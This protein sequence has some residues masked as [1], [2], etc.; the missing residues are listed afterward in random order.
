M[1]PWAKKCAMR[2]KKGWTEGYVVGMIYLA[3]DWQR[4]QCAVTTCQVDLPCSPAMVNKAKQSS[5]LGA[6][7]GAV[8]RLL[9]CKYL[10]FKAPNNRKVVA[11]C[12]LLRAFSWIPARSQSGNTRQGVRWHGTCQCMMHR[13]WRSPGEMLSN[14]S[15]SS[16]PL[17]PVLERCQFALDDTGNIYYY[18]TSRFAPESPGF[19]GHDT[20][21]RIFCH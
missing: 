4:G 1:W 17:V 11:W 6:T 15:S 3:G 8:V 16:S 7:L 20:L 13:S 14:R 18:Q 5:A 2:G 12:T 10:L 9:F 21:C 19:G